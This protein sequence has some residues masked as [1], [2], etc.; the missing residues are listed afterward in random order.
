MERIPV[1]SSSLNSVGHEGTTLEIEFHNG[2]IYRYYKVPPH[3]YQ[4]L[5]NTESY[6]QFFNEYIINSYRSRKMKAG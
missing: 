6:G 1:T 2:S 4:G 5:I 3:V